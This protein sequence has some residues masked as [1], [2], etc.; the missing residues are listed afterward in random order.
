MIDQ[1][2]GWGKISAENKLIFYI[3]KQERVDMKKSFI[4]VLKSQK[5]S[6]LSSVEYD[7]ISDL[8]ISSIPMNIPFKVDC[9]DVTDGRI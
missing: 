1:L 8:L 3:T 2:A 5:G 4:E 7:D 9:L 6:K